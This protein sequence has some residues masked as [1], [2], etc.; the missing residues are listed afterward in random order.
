MRNKLHQFLTALA[1]VLTSWC[2]TAHAID[3]KTAYAMSESDDFGKGIYTFQLGDSITDLSLFQSM[4]FDHVSGG[5]LLGDTYYYLDYS[6]VYNGYKVNGLYAFDMESK[7]A[8]LVKDYEA[9]QNGTIASC[10]TYDYQTG[11]M[12]G[13]NSFNGGSSLSVIDLETGTITEK[14][15]LTL[16]VLCDAAKASTDGSDHMH[17][18]TGNYDGDFWGVSYWGALYK[19]NKETGACQYI[20]TL[21]YN[22]GQAFMYTGDDL[23]YDEDNNRLMMRFTTYNWTTRTWIYEIFQIDTKTAHVTHFCDMDSKSSFHAITVP[24]TVAEAS[25]PAKAQ[26]FTVTPG[27]A[28]ALT[29]KLEWDNPSKTYGRGGTLEELD[30]MLIFR[31]G[32]LVDSIANP[33]IGAHMTWTDNLAERG[34]YTYKLVGGNGVGRGDRVSLG[35]Y[36][37]E[38]NP[39]GVTDA[40]AEVKGDGTTISWTAPTEGKLGSYINQASLKY[41][42]VR[43]SNSS[44]VGTKV[45]EGLTATTYDDNALDSIA[46][47]SYAIVA[48]TEKYA[49][50]SI[51]TDAI[52]AGP[53]YQVPHTFAFNSQDEF[54]LWKV[55]DA[56]G[57]Y[58]YWQWSQGYYGQPKG[59]TCSYNYDEL[60]AADWLISP[61]VR[62]EAGKHYKMTFDATP[63][64]KKVIETLAVSMGQG[65]EIADQDSITQWDIT[66]DGTISLR[67]NLPVVQ[68]TGDYNLGFLYRS[69]HSVNYNLTVGNVQIAE[70]HEGYITGT[71][72][73]AGKPVEG[74]AVYADGGAFTATT[75]ADGRFKLD[76][77]SAGKHTVNVIALGYEDASAEVEVSEYQTTT[78]DFALTAL[79]T[80]TVCG[81]VKDVAG[82]AVV[83]AEV[84]LSGYDTKGTTTDANGQFSFTN[85]FKNG[86]YAVTVTKNKLL[87]GTKSFGVEADTDLGTI[88]LEDNIKPAGTITATEDGETATIEWKAPANDATVQRI[89]DGT[90]TT[91]VGIS[92]YSSNTQFGVVKREPATVSGVQFYIDGTA[93]V[94]HYSVALTIFNLNENGEPTDSILYKNSYVSASDGKWNYYTLPAP[95]EAPNGYYI[96]LSSYQYLAVGID[97]DGDSER[98]PFVKNVNCFTPDYTTGNFYYLDNQSNENYRHNFL[99]RPVAAPMTVAEDSTE[100]HAPKADLFVRT[101]NRAMSDVELNDVNY[102]QP[103]HFD[104]ATDSQAGSE[105]MRTPQSRI[106]YNVYRMKSA[107][108]AN[109]ANWTLV[110]EKQQPRSF[111]DSN[112]KS[113]AQGSYAYAVKAVY[114]GDKLSTAV[115]TDTIGNKM[116]T[117]VTI[118]ITTDT[119]DNEAYGASVLFV[120]GG[121]RHVASGTADANG[122]VTLTGVWKDQYNV[123]VSLDGF[124]TFTGTAD[125]SQ[126]DA[127]TFSYKLEEDRI[128][129]YSLY[130]E[131]GETATSKVFAWNYPAYFFDDFESHE[132]FALNSAGSIGWQ[133]V[134]GDGASTGGFSSYTWANAFQPM[135][136]IVFNASATDPSTEYYYGLD[137]YSGKKCLQDWAAYNVANDDWFITPKLHFQQDFTYSFYAAGMD[138]SYPETFQVLYSTTDAQTSSFV[139]VADAQQTSSYYQYYSYSIPKEA[140][141]VALHC[142]SD[143]QRVFR[144]DDVTVGNPDAA[145]APASLRRPAGANHA[146]AKSPS[147][148]G[149]YEVYLD[150]T[151]VAQQDETEYTFHNL[152]SGKHTAGVI[153]SYTSGKTAMST[154]DFEVDGTTGIESVTGAMKVSVANR[155]VTVKGDCTSL[156]VYAADGTEQSLTELGDGNYR[157]NGKDGV[158]VVKATGKDGK[159]HT[160]KVSVE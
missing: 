131:D 49:S 92:S 61:R 122:D 27:E 107:D 116:S 126:D 151:M 153:A 155:T 35:Q 98:Y 76:Y 2:G 24:F 135:A 72:T 112:W 60:A 95:V 44:T 136:F 140:K 145:S 119:P 6:Q 88:T 42:I 97:G 54:N 58:V 141:Y 71:V 89:D 26:N 87:E 132:D 47:Y 59:A 100:F 83:G 123:T 46:K 108:L 99:I 12:Y 67:A 158:Y 14:A 43:Y 28:G 50:D 69:Y 109:E 154:I 74:A 70:D 17:V 105:A 62:L 78:S 82:D 23:F 85:V 18:M 96:A 81:T 142:T 9:A 134:D 56:N 130:I 94:T 7:T 80:Y 118:H 1:L 64:S 147:L 10:F 52:V 40:T 41:D 32:Q 113:L 16:D 127:Y 125:V 75:D 51:K 77:L 66:A 45:V 22:P 13:L 138:Y 117:T 8:K 34:Y 152:S 39:L 79:P 25:A 38:G 111:T 150:G 86:N 120:A 68:N 93:S 3:A 84:A 4:T 148:D 143:Q 5:Y 20:G 157:I 15:Q 21:D 11:T 57:N 36:I 110:S 149:L 30:Y 91:C 146:P 73:C 129:P 103:K 106:R 90:V 137:A 65:T 114:T 102:E 101:N 37:G 121:G 55:I 33:A 139:P 31:D 133:Y 19:I 115:L 124:K 144:V 53:A 160:M 104:E 159:S 128:Q 48:R 156:S 63:G 29:A